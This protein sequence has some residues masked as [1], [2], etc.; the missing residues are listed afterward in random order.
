MDINSLE[1]IDFN[2]RVKRIKADQFFSNKKK[3][4]K[5]REKE[6]KKK[7]QIDVRV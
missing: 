2:L 4:S 3:K 7:N 1:K 5:N 6:N